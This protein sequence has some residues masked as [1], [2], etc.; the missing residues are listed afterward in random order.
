MMG[1]GLDTSIAE[2]SRASH[3]VRGVSRAPRIVALAGTWAGER[4]QHSQDLS[5][6]RIVLKTK[7][8]PTLLYLVIST[9]SA[10][11]D[12]CADQFLASTLNFF[13]KCEIAYIKN[14]IFVHCGSLSY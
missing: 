5:A 1:I 13:S 11:S 6:L 10:A 2:H 9:S 8:L 14:N 12:P 3:G 7:V 4:L